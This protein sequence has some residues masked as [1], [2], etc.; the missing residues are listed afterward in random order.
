MVTASVFG[1]DDRMALIPELGALSVGSVTAVILADRFMQLWSAPR[2]GRGLFAIWASALAAGVMMEVV[3]FLGVGSLSW[4][5]VGAA[6]GGLARIVRWGG[7]N[8]QA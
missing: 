1:S 2:R 4:L 3:M 5:S 6:I 7:R 8:D